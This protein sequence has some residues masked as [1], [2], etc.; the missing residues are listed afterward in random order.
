MA[1]EET[2][3]ETEDATPSVEERYERLAIFLARSVI[4]DED[5]TITARSRV[6]RGQLKVMVQIPEEHRGRVIGRG[7]HMIRTLRRILTRAGI[8]SP[9]PVDFDIAE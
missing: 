5:V 2:N 7:G 4:P 1:T 3:Q 6:D 8:E 9:H